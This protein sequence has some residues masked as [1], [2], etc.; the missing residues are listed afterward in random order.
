[1]GRTWMNEE[2]VRR[3]GILA[4]VKTGEMT[5]REA[6]ERLQL[7]YRQTKRLYQRYRK[8]GTAGL[9]H[10]NAGKRSHHAKDQKLKRR[11]LTLVR[12]QYGGSTEERFGPTLAAEHLAED[13]GIEVDA[14]T[15]RRWM[16][17]EGLWTR[18]R[19]ASDTANAGCDGNISA[20]WCRWTVVSTIG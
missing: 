2:E 15:L 5:R 8:E 1:M 16:L 14:E 17:A 11:V 4:R 9:V 3:A 7:S 19:N 13:H 10:G 12:T 20:N 6:A 18:E